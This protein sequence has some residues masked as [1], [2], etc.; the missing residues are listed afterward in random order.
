VDNRPGEAAPPPAREPDE[1]RILGRYRTLQIVSIVLAVGGLA[2]VL[3]GLT[4][5]PRTLDPGRSLPIDRALLI[6]AAVVGGGLAVVVGLVLNSVRAVIVRRALPPGRYRGPSVIVLLLMATILSFVV[7]ILAFRD[8]EAL[9][10]GGDI[11]AGG[12]LLIL[13]ATQM[14]LVAVAIGFV[15]IPQALAGVRLRPQRGAAVSMLL[16]V[17]LAIPAWIGT[18]LVVSIVTRLLELLGRTPQPGV[19]DQ[20]IARVDPTVLLVAIVLVAPVAEELFFRG[21]VFNAWLREYGVRAAILGSAALFAAI[22]AD[23]SSLD[24]LID[25]LAKVVSIF[26]LGVGLAVLYQRTRSLL[27]PIAMHA[28]FNAISLTLALLARLYGWDLPT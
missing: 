6:L 19:V 24:T 10:G 27:A 13:T 26:G 9:L 1:S 28:T 18:I 15:A 16:G 25:S 8:I 3:L 22:H 4:L 2:G 14:G 17:L 5:A 20:A 12:G 23:P 21:V 7:S 11:S